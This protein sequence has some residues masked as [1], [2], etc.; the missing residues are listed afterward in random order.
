MSASQR[1]GPPPC[2]PACEQLADIEA[3]KQLKA[4]YFRLMDTKNWAE[5][6]DVFTADAVV[7][8]GDQQIEG[9]AAIV[10]FVAATSDGVRSAHQGFLPEIKMVAAGQARGVWA[11]SDYF[12]LRGTDPAVGFSGFGHYEDRYARE[13]GTWRISFSRLTR[14]KVI[15]LPGG[16]PEFYR[17]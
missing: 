14:I 3:I 15:P 4:R 1:P 9:R 11:M 16:L 10:E 13:D 8:G 7:R 2:C 6:A 5:L 12:E 17:R